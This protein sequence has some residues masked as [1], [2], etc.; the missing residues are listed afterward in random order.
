M[1]RVGREHRAATGVSGA[2]AADRGGL[3]WPGPHHRR[4]R[5]RAG[6]IAVSKTK[7]VLG[8]ADH[9]LNRPLIDGEVHSPELDLDIVWQP[10]DG[11][12][13]RRML[14]EGAYDAC[15]FSICNYLVLRS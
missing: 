1:C 10:E 15:E 11:E 12:R 2:V 5:S 6:R 7:L 4:G 3:L 9:D 13:H 8:V 14:R